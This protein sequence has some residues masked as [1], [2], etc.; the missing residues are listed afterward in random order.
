M[1]SRTDLK[2]MSV[3]S[4]NREKSDDLVNSNSDENGLNKPQNRR[5][6]EDRSIFLYI[7]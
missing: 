3:F 5:E 4:P 6:K 1:K 2:N 7:I